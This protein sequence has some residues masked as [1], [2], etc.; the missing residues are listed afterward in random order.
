MGQSYANEAQRVKPKPP[1]ERKPNQNEKPKPS[2]KWNDELNKM[3][4][5]NPDGSL[6]EEA[7]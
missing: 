2:L 1:P 5:T 7:V 6:A 4:L 3:V